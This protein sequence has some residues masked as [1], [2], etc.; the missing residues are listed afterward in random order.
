MYVYHEPSNSW[1]PLRRTAEYR[2]K[3]RIVRD[4]WIV[5]GLVMMPLSPAASLAVALFCTFL[6]LAFLDESRY[7]FDLDRHN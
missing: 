6:S 4:G 7:S 3:R 2:R 1:I 5:A